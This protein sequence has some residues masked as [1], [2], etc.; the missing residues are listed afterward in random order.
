MI[1]KQT[2]DNGLTLLTES[3]PAARSVAVG[4]WLKRGS[5]HESPEEC[6]ISH[7]IEHMVFKG[8]KS[9]SAERIAAE[10]DSIGGYM[11]AFTTKEYA[12]FHLKVL[13]EHLPLAVE[14]LGD[15]VLNPL[16]DPE[17]MAKEK[18]VIFEEINLVED[19]PDDLVMELFTSAFWPG[20]PLG[21]PILGSKR[22]VGRFRRGHLAGFFGRVY[23]PGN[24]I[25]SAAGHLDHGGTAALV[26]RHFGALGQGRTPANGRPP[27]AAAR[28]VTRSKRQLEQV[29]ICLGTRAHPQTHPDRY[30]VHILNT[31]LGGSMSSRLFQNVRE[32]RGLVYAISSGVTAYSDAGILSV[33][34][35]TSRES[36]PEVV[37]LTLEEI[38]RLRGERIPPDEL[39]R[40]KD[41]IKGSLM[42]SLESS[43]ARMSHLAR[44]EIYFARHFEL[45]E[46]VAAIEAVTADDVHRV[47]AE[48][49]AGRLAASVLGD[50]RGWRPRGRDLQA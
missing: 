29:H 32:K 44:Q 16:F 50:L 19:T 40:A 47:A 1:V 28:T 13:D 30:V 17:E 38:R 25:V 41:H 46:I 36:A 21:R 14:I 33:Y 31:V 27:R 11:D 26:R 2:L 49:F 8:T 24:I 10:V 35:G 43:G 42:L 48:L 20:H 6:G 12:S 37:R 34:A 3:M 7:F 5:R 9:R 22:S 18:K 15:I 4:V 23:H 45:D 39:R